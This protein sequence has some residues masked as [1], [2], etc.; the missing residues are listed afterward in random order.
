MGQPGTPSSTTAPPT[1]L[2]PYHKIEE[3]I[4]DDDSFL[5]WPDSSEDLFAIL[6][7][8]TSELKTSTLEEEKVEMESFRFHRGLCGKEHTVSIE[9]DRYP[10]KYW[11]HTQKVMKL[12]ENDNSDSFKDDSCFKL[13][14]K[15][16]EEGS[17][18]FQSVNLVDYSIQVDNGKIELK[19][20]ALGKT[21]WANPVSLQAKLAYCSTNVTTE[22][23]V[24][25]HPE[26]CDHLETLDQ[27]GGCCF[28]LMKGENKPCEPEKTSV[29]GGYS[30][31]MMHR[32]FPLMKY[33]MLK[34]RRP[35][36]HYQNMLDGKM[37]YCCLLPYFRKS[38]T[39]R[40]I[41]KDGNSYRRKKRD[42][43]PLKCGMRCREIRYC[44]KKMR[45]DEGWTDANDKCC[46]HPFRKR[47]MLKRAR[48]HDHLNN[49]ECVAK[50]YPSICGNASK[51]V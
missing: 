3:M 2:E 45:D 44:P 38:P 16:C 10:G 47:V 24:Y 25:E 6:D 15:D 39:F 23:D 50:E 46:C 41:C 26:C 36:A 4:T 42:A 31:S 13:V 20:F 1:T 27:F 17:F 29:S 9:S 37:K 12:E 19:K 32:C 18:A 30:A 8:K 51:C 22:D 35:P 5:V 28:E 14:T 21:C 11:R 49:E 34:S 40:R 43:S 48:F 33:A 7:N